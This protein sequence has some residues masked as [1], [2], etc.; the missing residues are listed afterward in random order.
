MKH[1]PVLNVH[2]KTLADSY[3]K[4]LFILYCDGARFNTQYDKPG[5]PKSI[6]ATMNITID[7]P[8]KDP[9][10]HKAFPGGFADLR[11]YVFELQGNKDHWVKNIND[12]DDK[13]W[14]YTYHGRFKNWGQWKEKIEHGRGYTYTEASFDKETGEMTIDKD[15]QSH[16]AGL[17]RGI[18]QIEAAID[19]LCKQPFT[20]QAQM[21]TWMPNLDLDIFDPPCLRS[22]W[23]RIGED[24]E[25]GIQYL[26]SNV[27]IRSNDAWNAYFMN[28]FGITMFNKEVIADEISR[29]TGKEVR[30]SRMNWQADSWHIYGKDI[31]QAEERL[32][33]RM[34]NT[35]FE[36][37]IYNFYDETIQEMYYEED[38][39]IRKKIEL[40]TQKM[41][42][43]YGS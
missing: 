42:E 26:N 33:N 17:V 27:S 10:I 1:I 11:E 15:P 24:E 7:E 4:A 35:D 5:D 41:E 34:N 8:L 29:R 43:E 13:R 20:R 36:D 40:E 18:D 19:K 38:D 22:I 21:I 32:F 3:E 12:L 23:Y 6:D 9:M 37:R 30:L 28:A 2:G 39:N 14:E 25:T 16:M 31:Q